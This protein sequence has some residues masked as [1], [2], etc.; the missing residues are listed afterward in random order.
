MVVLPGLVTELTATPER[1]PSGPDVIDECQGG[2]TTVVRGEGAAAPVDSVRGHLFG[3]GSHLLL[4]DV[5]I[6]L[7]G[8]RNREI[9]FVKL[10]P[11]PSQT[12]DSTDARPSHH[13]L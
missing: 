1:L 8:E 6:V 9:G 7:D 12:A 5:G 3:D 13:R 2:S 10:V 11:E 4:R